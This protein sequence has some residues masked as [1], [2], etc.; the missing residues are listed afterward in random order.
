MKKRIFAALLALSLSILCA[1][2]VAADTYTSDGTAEALVTATLPSTYMVMVP[3]T[4]T[5]TDPDSDTVYTGSYTIG[6][7]GNITGDEKIVCQPTAGS[8]TMTSADSTSV[9]ATVTQ[10]KTEWV[11]GTPT[12]TQK[13]LSDAETTGAY[14]GYAV[15][16][17]SIS[18]TITHSGTYTGNVEFT[19]YKE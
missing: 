14:S 1:V 18:A 13:R 11:Y 17:G 16:D 15:I 5:L 10:A 12:S 8:F 9:T 7:K 3:A 6:A 4:I 19:F 2:S